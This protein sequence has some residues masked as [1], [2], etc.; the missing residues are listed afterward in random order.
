MSVLLWIA[1]GFASCL[2]IGLRCQTLRLRH[3]RLHG[4]K[5]LFG[6]PPK[7]YQI[8]LDPFFAQLVGAIWLALGFIFFLVDKWIPSNL[9]G[10][11]IEDLGFFS[12]PLIGIAIIKQIR[13]GYAKKP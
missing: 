10:S 6:I 12:P 9:V 3:E 8:E 2:G 4:F 13:M 7:E 5:S 1:G 11:I